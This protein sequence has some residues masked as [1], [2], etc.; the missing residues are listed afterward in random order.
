M[1]RSTIIGLVIGIVAISLGLVL[2]GASLSA[3]WNPAAILIIFAGTAASLFI[4]FPMSEIKKFPKLIKVV[5]KKQKLTSKGEI[6]EM[7]IVMAQTARREGILYLESQLEQYRDPFVKKGVQLVVDGAEPEL[8][9]SLLTE[10][11]YATEERHRAGALIFSQAG[12]YA[13]TLGVLGAVIGLI[14]ALG[15]LSDIEKLG[16]SIA[17]AFIATLFGIFSGYVLWHPIANKL[18]RYSKRETEIKEIIIEGILA[19]QS[20][21]AP[22]FIEQYLLVFLSPDEQA[23]Y[24]S[25][26]G[27]LQEGG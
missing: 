15:N 22:A 25:Q 24:Y 16:H 17:A 9:R 18:K 20:G 5:F 23:L 26:K 6:I 27:V 7:F 2:K 3:L 21:T 19:V 14:A 4:G 12:T 11:I 8:V 13:P 1:E 10:Q